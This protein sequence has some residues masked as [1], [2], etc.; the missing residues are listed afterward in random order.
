M[1]TRIEAPDLGT[2]GFLTA[3]EY[4][5]VILGKDSDRYFF[6]EDATV[7]ITQFFDDHKVVMEVRYYETN[8]GEELQEDQVA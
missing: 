5:S 7:E 4:D 3:M 6:E 8:H 1:G 2:G